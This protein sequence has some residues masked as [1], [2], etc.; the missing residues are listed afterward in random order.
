[1]S[2]AGSF[3]RFDAILRQRYRVARA[4][5]SRAL[6]ADA[7]ET[8]VCSFL[9]LSLV[10]GLGANALWGWWW[11]DPAA[12]LTMVPLM[13]KEGSEALRGELYEIETPRALFGALA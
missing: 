2:L 10:V 5:G 7:M 12:A 1:L 4:L 13:V 8:A 11:A 6:E 3:G 9:S